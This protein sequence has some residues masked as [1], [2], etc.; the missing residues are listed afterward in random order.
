MGKRTATSPHAAYRGFLLMGILSVLVALWAIGLAVYLDTQYQHATGA[1]G[2]YA[3]NRQSFLKA[4]FPLICLLMVAA[5]VSFVLAF[6]FR[7]KMLKALDEEREA[8]DKIRG[9][10][11]GHLSAS[12]FL[13]HRDTLR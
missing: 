13:T 5:L 12:D 10:S 4:E 11:G 7:K 3:G 1:A 2:F 8:Y 9:L 6:V